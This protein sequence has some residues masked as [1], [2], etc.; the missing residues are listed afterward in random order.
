MWTDT[1]QN[2]DGEKLTERNIDISQILNP[3]EVFFTAMDNY[4][5]FQQLIY[6]FNIFLRPV[7]RCKTAITENCTDWWYAKNSHEIESLTPNLS[8]FNSTNNRWELI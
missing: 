2:Y 3:I 5:Y 6:R 4:Q 8:A 7:K 1:S